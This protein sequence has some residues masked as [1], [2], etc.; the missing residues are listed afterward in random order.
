MGAGGGGDARNFGPNA[1]GRWSGDDIRQFRREFREWQGD[2][3]ALRRQLEASGVNPRDLDAVIRD[4]RTLDSD[5]VYADPAGLE[6]L[7]AAALERLKKFEFELRKRVDSDH[8][9]LSLSGSDEVPAG[10]R[11]A[12]EEYYRS[13]AKK[14]K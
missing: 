9:A 5:Q 11:Q 3:D 2:A 8:D 14:S 1:G 4:L 12:I 6:K 10:F 7:Q 13:L